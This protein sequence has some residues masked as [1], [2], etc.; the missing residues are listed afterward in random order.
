MR[1]T[2]EEIHVMRKGCNADALGSVNILYESAQGHA[3]EN[4]NILLCE[5]ALV[6]QKK[7]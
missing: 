2:V 7:I 3:A 4:V 5:D 6:Q 1:A